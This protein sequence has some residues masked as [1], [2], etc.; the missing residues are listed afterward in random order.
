MANLQDLRGLLDRQA[1]A[2]VRFRIPAMFGLSDQ[3]F[4]SAM[5]RLGSALEPG[6]KVSLSGNIPL[7]IAFQP[8]SADLADLMS[9]VEARSAK[10]V[11]DMTPLA[12]SAFGVIQEVCIPRGDF[13]LLIDV[14]TGR[15]L[16]N[17][18]PE[19]ALAIIT[20]RGRT[21]LTMEEGVAVTLQYPELLTDRARYNCIQMPGSRRSGDQR[22]P[23]IWFS[24]GRP[25]L[26]WCWDRNVHSWLG[27]ASAACRI[28][29]AGIEGTG[30]S[31]P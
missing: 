18:S 14:D 1:E 30:R 31:A 6:L 19:R 15:N 5:D 7:C 22:V 28:G 17:I 12:P 23:S 4:A 16:L 24:R 21:P 9:R 3:D 13:Y 29:V 27:S 25:R 2:L 10:G 26:G 11:V 20:G 8:G